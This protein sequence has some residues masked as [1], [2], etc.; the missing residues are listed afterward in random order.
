MTDHL[1]KMQN[2]FLEVE[3]IIDTLP[4]GPQTLEVTRKK[5]LEL[6]SSD[7][8]GVTVYDHLRSCYPT[9]KYKLMGF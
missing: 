9:V 3:A 2:L 7:S 8:Y 4:E 5:D 6:R 1:T